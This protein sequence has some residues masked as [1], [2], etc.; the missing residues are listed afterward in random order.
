MGFIYTGFSSSSDGK[1][2]TYNARDPGLIPRLRRSPGERNGFLPQY[3]CLDNSTQIEK[4]SGL[5]SMGS[6]RVRHN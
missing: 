3:S 1:E 6:Q 5:Q 4:P 2:S